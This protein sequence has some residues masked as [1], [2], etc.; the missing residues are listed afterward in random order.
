[1]DYLDNCIDLYAL[2]DGLA[3]S[4]FLFDLAILVLP[5]PKACRHEV[6]RKTHVDLL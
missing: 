4:D 5:I 1:M 2:Y 6:V 3:I